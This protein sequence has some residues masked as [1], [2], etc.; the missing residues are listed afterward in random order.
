[1][2]KRIYY[3]RSSTPCYVKDEYIQQ[4]NAPSQK[5]GIVRRWFEESDTDFILRSWLA[6]SPDLNPNENLG[7]RFLIPLTNNSKSSCQE[8]QM[9]Y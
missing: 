5:A 3:R 4:N 2:P 7:S 8:E 9:Q 6:Q 1:M